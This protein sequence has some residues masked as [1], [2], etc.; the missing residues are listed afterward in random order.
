MKI[1]DDLKSKGVIARKRNVG[2]ANLTLKPLIKF[3][4]LRA[5]HN[6]TNSHFIILLKGI[7]VLYYL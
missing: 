3:Y 6:N 1:R 5:M 2:T 7:I 4:N